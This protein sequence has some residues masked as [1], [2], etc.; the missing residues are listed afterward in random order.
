[1]RSAGMDESRRCALCG[2]VI[3]GEPFVFEGHALCPVHRDEIPEAHWRAVGHYRREATAKQRED[4]LMSGGLRCVLLT[5]TEPPGY[6]L[7]IRERDKAEAFRLLERI[8]QEVVLCRGCG[9]EFSRDQV[10]CP[11]CGEKYPYASSQ[12]VYDD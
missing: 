7:F 11:F 2:N 8:H 1:L 4:L 3:E 5:T 10:F 9:L 12:D 6:T